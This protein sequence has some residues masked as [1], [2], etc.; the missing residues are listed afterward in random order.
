[1]AEAVIGNK[2]AIIHISRDEGCLA[3]FVVCGLAIYMFLSVVRHDYTVV[4][5]L[6]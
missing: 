5:F 6:A 4:L 2:A 1:M 3:I